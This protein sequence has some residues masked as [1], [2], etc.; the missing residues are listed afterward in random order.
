MDRAFATLIPRV[1]ASTPGC[2]DPTVFQHIRDAAIRACERSTAWRYQPLVYGLMPGVHEYEYQKP[3]NTDV[4]VLFAALLNGAPM[5]IMALEQAI[6]AYPRWADLYSGQPASVVWGATPTGTFNGYQFNEAVF[7]GE[8]SYVVPPEIVADGG[9]PRTVTQLTPDKYIVLPLPDAS[10]VYRMRM[11]LALKPKRTALGMESAILDE[12]EDAIVHC[13]LQHLLAL[14]DANWRD[15]ELAGYH[16]RQYLFHI[17]ERR[18]RANVGNMRATL[19]A[20]TQF[21]GV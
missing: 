1:Q 15:L 17:S 3:E 20:Q 16:A 8:P 13:A 12:L 4:H 11:F 9:E 6:R 7:N 19:R 5:E 2:P 18:A 21:F 14:P 10:Q